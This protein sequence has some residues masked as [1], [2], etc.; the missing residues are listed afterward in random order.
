VSGTPARPRLVRNPAAVAIAGQPAPAA[1][2]PVA[3]VPAPAPQA[4]EPAEQAQELAAPQPAD[5]SA[6]PGAQ[7]QVPVQPPA[8]E[9][10]ARVVPIAVQ[11]PAEAE[12]AEAA[13]GEEAPPA[14]TESAEV[15]APGCWDKVAAAGFS[16]KRESRSWTPYTPRLP[17]STWSALEAR[18]LADARRTGDYGIAVAHY[19][20]VA[21]DGL[22][23]V[24]RAARIAEAERELADARRAGKPEAV[25]LVMTDEL[26]RAIPADGAVDAR[27]AAR[28]GLDWLQKIGGRPG[29]LV[30]TGSRIMKSMKAEMQE[31]GLML[32]G[33]QPKVE[34]WVVQAAYVHALLDALEREPLP[35]IPES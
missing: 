34:L 5:D 19:L 23:R 31:L 11:P 26:M 12:E 30:P 27:A 18:K 13:E 22:P 29:A 21:F 25:L 2:P 14:G 10:S 9:P 35:G 8:A 16:A 28:A 4:A 15:P 7:D 24:N 1:V 33:Q 17:E 32:K 20:Q 6:L 3:S